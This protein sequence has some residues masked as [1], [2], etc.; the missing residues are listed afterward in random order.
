VSHEDF[1]AFAA[2]VV[3]LVLDPPGG[4]GQPIDRTAERQAEGT[5]MIKDV[6][7][8]QAG[9]WSVRVF[10]ITQSG[11]TIVLDAPIVIER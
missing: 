10:V 5:W 9:I 8:A 11:E 1:T 6:V 3:R 2:K 4:S 7:L